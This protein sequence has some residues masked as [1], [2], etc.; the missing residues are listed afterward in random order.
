MHH[1]ANKRLLI[2]VL[3]GTSEDIAAN[4]GYPGLTST[5]A[6]AHLRVSESK[7]RELVND[8]EIS[9]AGKLGRLNIF[10]EQEV[11]DLRIRLQ[12]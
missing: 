10:A 5:E 7:L 6:A 1:M 9:P 2:K 3:V 4:K 11:E 12:P 8:G